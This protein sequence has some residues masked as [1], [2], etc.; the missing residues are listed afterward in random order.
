MA[1]TYLRAGIPNLLR[2]KMLKADLSLKVGDLSSFTG[3]HSSSK[4]TLGGL[5]IIDLESGVEK[6]LKAE[7]GLN[8]E[9]LRIFLHFTYSSERGCQDGSVVRC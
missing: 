7:D 5:Q 1:A 4:V 2:T 9:R 6:T 3:V 8:R